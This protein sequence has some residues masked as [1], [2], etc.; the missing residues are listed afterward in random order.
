MQ[1]IA[2][3]LDTLN[4]L[5]AANS[6]RNK[7]YHS[8][9][10]KPEHHELRPLFANYAEQSRRFITALS[11][12]RSAYGGFTVAEQK[13]SWAG[14]WSQMKSLLD[15]GLRRSVL[16][17]CEAQEEEISKLYKSAI[18]TPLM[19]AATLTD[20]QHQSREFEKALSKLRLLRERPAAAREVLVRS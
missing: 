13:E 11:T 14:P 4:I 19:P 8:L 3:T 10:E 16:V 18:R 1:D 9:C 6:K 20:I 15:F 7:L 17:Q 5:I 12:W 2:R